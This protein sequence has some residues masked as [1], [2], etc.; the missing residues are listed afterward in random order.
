M[1]LKKIAPIF[2]VLFIFIFLT[3][4]NAQSCYELVWNDEFNYN[5]LPDSS[6]WSFEEGGNGWGNNEL[7]Y[8]TSKRIENA[9]VENGYLTIEA[10]KENYNGREYTSARLI[11]YPNNYSWKYGKIEARIKLPYGQGIWPAF[12]ALG[13]G[14]FEGTSWPACGEI[15]IMELVG[16]GEGYDDV[17]HGTMHYSDINNN[18][19]SYGDYYQLPEGIFADNFHVFSI[20]W[21]QTQLTWFVDGIQ[22]HTA[23]LTPSYLTE[24]HKDFFLLLNIAV[25]GDWP[26]SPNSSTVFPQKMIVDYV[27]V[28]QLN[29]QPEIT[30]DTIINKA[31]KNIKYKTVESEEFTYNWSVPVGTTITKGQGTNSIY[32]TWD[33]EPGD[34]TCHL[35]TNCNTYDL[36]LPVK[37]QQIEIS[38]NEKVEVLSENNRYK[39]PELNATS[40]SWEAPGEVTFIGETDTNIVYVNWGSS[41]GY[42]IVNTSNNCGTEYDSIYIDIVEQLP[43]PDPNVKHKIPGTIQAADFDYGGEGFAYHDSD[44]ENQGAGLRQDEGVDT[45]YNDG[46][47]NIGWIKPGEWV[48]Y[49]VEVENTELF[50]IELRVAS[51]NGGGEMEIHFNDENRTGQISIPRTGSWTTFTS[52]FLNEI[53]LYDLDSLMKLQFNIG[54]FNISRLIFTPTATLISNISSNLD[55][56]ALYPNPA[57]N[58]LHLTN[59]KEIFN[60]SIINLLGGIEQTGRLI[61][62]NNINV[63]NLSKGVYFLNLYSNKNVNTLKFIKL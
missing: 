25:G 45:E 9:H 44:P 6:L 1:I 62:G 26:G 55:D 11:T 27:R 10:R 46:G 51:L 7:Q 14:I 39:L 48:E 40:Y 20:E 34:V 35:I 19:A 5:G 24:L 43:F 28:Y 31:Q 22:Y 60:Y 54:D 18:H 2:A 17:V 50:D 15:D 41:A 47:Q 21:T 57:S 29:N 3:N 56:V 58:I 33:C 4:I 38:G 36:T 53:Q 37:T 23:S 63:S 59:Q 42:L 13:D 52:V 16:G 49:T 8:Y 30:G 32:V 61:P 12:W